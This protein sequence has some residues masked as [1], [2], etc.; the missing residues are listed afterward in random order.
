MTRLI[1]FTICILFVK[2]VLAQSSNNFS[3][4]RTAFLKEAI[5]LLTDTK[6]EDCRQ[7]ADNLEKSWPTLSASAQADIIEI[8]QA[9]RSRKMLVT[10]YFLKFFNTIIAYPLSKQDEDFFENWKQVTLTVLSGLK[11]GNNKKFEDFLDF[12]YA[13][14]SQHAF[15]ITEG[16]TWK[17]DGYDYNL[18][19]EKSDPVL[20]IADCTI[21]GISSDDSIRIEETGGSYFPLDN[22]WTGMK[23]RVD[24]SRVGFG[25]DEVY[26]TFG[27]YSIDFRQSDYSVDSA[28]LFYEA[29][30]KKNIRGKFSDKILSRANPETSTYP[31]FESYRKDL[32]FDD[33]A[34]HVKLFG[35]I[36]LQGAKMNT[37]G[38]AEHKAMIKIYRYDKLLGV[39]AQSKNF[40][41]NKNKEINSS[42]AEVKLI[43]GK[44]SMLHGGVALRYNSEKR[45]LYLFRGQN[46]IEKSPFYDYY[47]QYEESPDVI[48]WDMNEPT[49]YMRNISQSGQSTVTMESFDYYS[50]G[51]MDKFQ[52]IADYNIIEKL[53]SIVESSGQK[54]FTTEDLA[55]R[56]S[57]TYS[58]PTI[59]GILYKLV[60][61]GFIDYDDQKEIVTV[62][63]KTFHYVQAKQKKVDYDNIRIDSKT[64]SVNAEIDMRSLDMHLRGVK[65]IVLSDSNFVVVF[66]EDK[67]VT[68]KQNRNMDFSGMMFAGRLDMSGNGFS[69]DYDNFRMDLTTVD[70]AIINI[71]TGKFDENHKPIVGPIKSVIEKVTG[72]LQIDTKDNRSG[73][74]K[75]PQFPVLTT[76]QP[77]F[78]YYDNPKILGG[79]YNRNDFYFSIDP[80]AFDSLNTF[81]V[82]K[83]GFNGKLVSGGI[84][85]EMKDRLTIQQDLSLGFKTKKQDIAL[86]G[87]KGSFTN[88]ISLDNSG[89][90]GKG[91]IKFL[92][93]LTTSKDIIFFPDSL[94]A[95]ADSFIMN[96]TV[97]NSVEY[98]TVRG[99]KDKVHW[100]PDE[101][102][103]VVKMD[104][105]PFKIFDG[106]TTMRGNLVLQSKGLEG[107][108][109]VDWSDATLSSDVIHFGKNKMNSD[110]ADFSIKS[111]D[112]KKFALKTS[113]VNASIDFDKRIGTFK[114]NT[115]DIS[116]LFPY[117]QYRTSIN[118]FK[119]D[120]DKKKMTF[121]APQGTEADFTSVHPD[122]DSLTFNG[123]SATYDLQNYILKVNKVPYI[124]VADAR[125]F[126]DS[127]KVVIEADAK[128]RTLNRAKITMDTIGEYHKFDSVVA[129]IY[130]KK[131]FKATGIYSFVNKTGKPQKIHIDDIGVFR[132]TSGRQL[133]TYA[134]GVIDTSQRFTL[135]PKVFFKGKANII[136]D[137][138][139]VEFKGYAKLDINNPKVRA[140]WFS[141]DNFF[142][143]DSSYVYYKDPENEAHRPMTAGMV[144]DAD[145]S[146]LYTIFFNSK[147]SSKDKNLFIA[148]GIVFYDQTAKE[149]V[150]GEPDKILN[151]AAR[152]NVLRYNDASGKVTAEGKM[153]LGLNYGMVDIM[154]AGSVTTDVNKNNPVFTVALG[155][156]FDIDK[157]LL[158][159][160]QKSV[161]QGNYDE[162]EADYSTD[163]F[164]KAIPEFLDPKHEKTFNTA[165]NTTNSF[166]SS[167]ALPYTIFF[168]DVELKWDKTTKAFYNTK[169]FTIAFIGDKS[170]ARTVPGYIELGYKRSGDYMNLYIPAGD[171]DFWYYF[172][173]A[174]GNMQIVAGEQ[175]F[176]EAL[177]KINPD[178]RR[179][180]SK[181]GKSYQYNPGS[182]NKK[183]TFV[184]RIKFLQGEK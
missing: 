20:K 82:L 28:S 17:F 129:N 145:S 115:D 88:Q 172:Y 9:M 67:A 136:S 40:D 118:E 161:L 41:I 103:F 137:R 6:R 32:E 3:D 86:Y 122:Q 55:K 171:E 11:Q 168:S 133:H 149:F 110:S 26:A 80:F 151:G 25:T 38:T 73:K 14:F 108:G 63:Y 56:I 177:V 87:G 79:A 19:M 164:Q 121:T 128:M 155:I 61:D 36:A 35:G 24:W 54:E 10:P 16:R 59:K 119:W 158:A 93:S 112:P 126:P 100:V 142:N 75:H 157:D 8:A 50:A 45:E 2:S 182:E 170:V 116:T 153:N 77:S 135:I 147:K 141:I 53:K 92:P 159:M 132:D 165:L 65:D 68:M 107:S 71:P 31:R 30:N 69:F 46:G 174:A 66:P 96:A 146:D 62:R 49:V 94:N 154:S 60:E 104:T 29:F 15:Y 162:G 47:H 127:G 120:M 140:E 111:L 139:P 76:T 144:F 78:V 95:K 183:N 113:D 27:K 179:S 90:R 148:N 173:Y 85:P 70:S 44:D 5:Q 131:S 7:A 176:N 125:I 102:S 138:E 42:Q 39:V 52:N 178:K 57:P 166:V 124:D 43:M 99:W 143:K 34:P 48:F 83:V 1:F 37:D 106:N 64:D 58:T 81:D 72:T 18:V 4:D 101:D 169:P 130:G 13:L 181:D 21:I 175:A 156:R 180:D 160:M 123:R 12:S 74:A 97:L 134:K 23:G 109:F 89:L 150:A 84:F 114:S 22:K 105:V 163:A 152:G 33:I 117:N 184:N 91:T 98:P 167:E 51:K